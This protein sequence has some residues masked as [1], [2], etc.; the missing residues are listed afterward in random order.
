MTTTETSPSRIIDIE[1]L[2]FASGAH[3]LL[4]RA[5]RLVPA[6]ERLGVRASAQDFAVHLRAWCRAQGH[7]YLE[8]DDQ[9]VAWIVRGSAADGRW[10]QAER[11]GLADA[12]EEGA[13]LAVPPSNWG[14]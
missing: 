4:K 10:R 6:G 7:E 3:L 8:G 12:R 13:V 1:E 11:A 9:F 2:S 14:F 5:L